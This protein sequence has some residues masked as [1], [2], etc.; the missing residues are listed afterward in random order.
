MNKENVSVIAVIVNIALAVFK[1]SVG[2]ITNSSAVFAAGIDS[3]VDILSS[4]LNLFGVK[5]SKKPVD[6]E[7]PYG[8]YKFEVMSGLIIT[9]ILFLT[10]AW[11]LYESY[12]GF[13]SP[14]FTEISYLALGVM[15]FSAAANEIM[16]RIKLHYGK[17]EDSISLITDGVHSR[18][19][20]ISSVVVF[21]GLFL[22]PVFR[23][24][25]PLLTLLIGLYII[26]E[27]FRLGKEATDSLLDVSAGE[28]IENKI[29][30]I[31]KSC[32]TPLSEIKTQKKGSA[33]T[34][35]L[36]IKL[37]KSL[38]VDKATVISESLR[39]RLMENI[40]SLHYVA[41]Q[42]SSHDV[43]NSYYQPESMI[44]GI[45]AGHGFGWQVKGRFVE[46]VKGAKGQGPGGKCACPKCGYE[47]G[48]QRGV[49]CSTI[50]CPKCGSTMARG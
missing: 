27:S 29:R 3:A 28:E 22:T 49:P 14:A 9:I 25:D 21:I 6:K 36:A 31:A 50:K 38:S 39:K 18:V 5:A 40:P 2:L 43:E 45:K 11:I 12:K 30:S 15:A 35:N 7:H 26:K 42:I 44:P 48:H 37:D 8:H 46:K 34:A 20:V 32:N 41:V 19:D 10:G 23:Y 4:L 1:T 47:T 16:A 13:L 24:S 17:K 33:I